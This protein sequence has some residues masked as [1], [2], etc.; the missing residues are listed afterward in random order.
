LRFAFRRVSRPLSRARRAWRARLI[1]AALGGAILAGTAAILGVA[2]AQPVTIAI[3]GEAYPTR[4]RATTVAETLRDVGVVISAG[5]QIAPPPHTLIQRDMIIRVERAHAVR[6]VIDGRARVVYTA[7]TQPAA[8]LTEANV[9]VRDPDRVVIDGTETT[10]DALAR[11]TVPVSTISIRHAFRLGIDD[12]MRGYTIQTTAETVG[13]A[14]FDAGITLYLADRVTPALDTPLPLPNQGRVQIERA[15]P[16]QIAADGATT[17]T[18]VVGG[19]VGAAL[20]EAGIALV[21]LDTVTPPE[22]APL[23]D[24]LLIRV[25]RV[26]EEL[27]TR[28]VT[29]PFATI[30][31]PDAARAAGE[32]AILDA[33]RVGMGRAHVRVRYEDGLIAAQ[34]AEQLETIRAPQDRV[35]AYG[36]DDAPAVRPSAPMG[37]L[38]GVIP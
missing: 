32:R 13:A 34:V 12:G 9:T 27:Q 35:I 17:R 19:S 8:I 6:L 37:A 24:Q 15:I 25:V 4:T 16:I 33:G 23:T 2:Q 20:A 18:R 21:G 38:E 22:D 3:D 30:Y 7:L 36:V 11:W 14:L 28:L 10:I 29:L 31:Q 26:R 1:I 5:D